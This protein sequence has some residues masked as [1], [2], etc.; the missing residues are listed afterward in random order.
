MLKPIFCKFTDSWLSDDVD[1]RDED[2]LDLV[3][4]TA[5]ANNDIL[6]K[7]FLFLILAATS[8][9]IVL[10]CNKFICYRKGRSMNK[11]KQS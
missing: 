10:C 1:L 6:I 7:V 5:E 9:I 11:F 2:K 3:D 4:I 8:A